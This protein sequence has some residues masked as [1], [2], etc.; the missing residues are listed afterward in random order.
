MTVLE[1]VDGDDVQ[2]GRAVGQ[3]VVAVTAPYALE[4]VPA[5]LVR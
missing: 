2:T 3:Q 5:H 4:L 1:L